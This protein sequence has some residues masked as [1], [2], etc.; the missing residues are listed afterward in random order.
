MDDPLYR[1]ETSRLMA[2]RARRISWRRNKS[3][4]MGAMSLNVSLSRSMIDLMQRFETVDDTSM[5]TARNHEEESDDQDSHKNTA[6]N[7]NN[8]NNANNDD[9]WM[10]E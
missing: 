4:S 2:D 10:D 6:N 3:K 9:A 1:D 8:N 5:K 7:N